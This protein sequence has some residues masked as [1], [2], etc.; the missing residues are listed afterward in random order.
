[1][2]KNQ[3]G[4]N[5]GVIWNI[6]DANKD[7]HVWEVEELQQTSGL[8]V[9]DFYAAIGWLARENKVDFGEDGITHH[10]TVGPDCWWARCSSSAAYLSVRRDTG[11]V[12]RLC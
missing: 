9:P 5:A 1:M 7:K 11:S 12:S 8:A 3:I 4:L 10:G 6:L 2:D